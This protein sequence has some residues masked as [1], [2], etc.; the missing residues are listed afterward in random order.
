MLKKL[1][2]KI[3]KY[4]IVQTLL[5]RFLLPFAF[6]LLGFVGFI[7][8][9]DFCRFVL[10]CRFIFIFVGFVVRFLFVFLCLFCFV[11]V[12]FVF[13]FGVVM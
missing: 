4:C 11:F 9:F 3:L 6:V 13:V 1:C 10:C 2:G 5:L 8:L 7:S 12:F